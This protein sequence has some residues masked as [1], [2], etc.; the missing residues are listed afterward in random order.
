VV[1]DGRDIGSQVLPNAPIKIYLDADPTIRAQRRY[2]ELIA[3][4]QPAELSQVLAETLTR[5]HR[6][7]NRAHAPLVQTDDAVYV[8]ASHMN[9]T[10]TVAFIVEYVRQFMQK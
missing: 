3:K 4:G 8:D 2:R 9:A 6:D 7:K 1:M 10:E 5:D